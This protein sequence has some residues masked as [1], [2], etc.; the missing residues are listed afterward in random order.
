MKHIMQV[1]KNDHVIAFDIDDTLVMWSKDY[2]VK[3]KGRLKFEDP[4]AGPV[5]LTPHIRHIDLLKNHFA[6][7][8]FIVAWSHGGSAWTK[9]VIETLELQNYVHLVITKPTKLVDDLKP[10]E[11]FPNVIYLKNE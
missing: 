1:I 9:N 5:Y 3:K 6:R 2:S 8:F 7:G 11:I 10:N 4:G